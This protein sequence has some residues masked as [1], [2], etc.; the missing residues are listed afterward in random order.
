MV[1]VGTNGRLGSGIAWDSE[2]HILTASHLV[3]HLKTVE[4]RLSEGDAREASVVGQDPYSDV[5]L[6]KT[7]PNG[8]KPVKTGDS[9]KL[10]VGQ[11]VLAMAN[12]Y[13]F[14][15]S[16][17][18]GII[19]SLNRT[20]RGWSGPTLDSAIVTDARL[21]PGYSGGPLVDAS[22]Q[23]IGL[24][25]AFVS[26]RG[27]AVP[28]HQVKTTL[29]RLVRDGSV[30]TGYL[31]IVSNPIPLPDE[32]ARLP[33]VDQSE[34]LIVLSVE[35][36]SPA[37]QGGLAFGDILLKFDSKTVTGLHDLSRYLREEVIG[38]SIRV[39]VLRGEKP[40]ELTITPRQADA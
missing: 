31:G 16:A 2:G 4:V 6:L 36:G 1:S 11:F 25:V 8:L 27:I 7:E 12:P 5:A 24:D 20:I 23:V 34:G 30:K 26:G 3:R 28:I 33:D 19:T 29:E 10:R 40:T 32:V 22:G 38:R 37:R 14:R 13:A 15:P 17:T 39:R 21:N 35:K 18:S 9:N